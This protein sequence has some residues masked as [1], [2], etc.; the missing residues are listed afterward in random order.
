MDV[1]SFLAW[2]LAIWSCFYTKT[3]LGVSNRVV[4]MNFL[5]FMNKTQE[6]MYAEM[7]KSTTADE[8]ACDVT[9][10][11][12]ADADAD[13]DTDTDEFILGECE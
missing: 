4:K 10:D 13:A 8:I 6:K 11:S 1:M 9:A 5:D 12:D 2:S 3:A 7:K